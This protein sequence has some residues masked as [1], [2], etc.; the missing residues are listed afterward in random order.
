MEFAEGGWCHWPGMGGH[1][2]AQLTIL[3]HLQPPHK[4]ASQQHSFGWHQRAWVGHISDRCA[5]FNLFAMV[6]MPTFKE[7]SAA[8]DKL[9]KRMKLI[10]QCR[11]RGSESIKY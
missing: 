2:D 4:D 6:S 9:A 10:N 1:A 7:V 8:R 3:Y 5:I 11:A